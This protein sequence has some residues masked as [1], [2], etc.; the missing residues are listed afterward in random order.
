MSST[1][2]ANS[3]VTPPH[4]HR[5]PCRHNSSPRPHSGLASHKYL[6]LTKLFK[7]KNVPCW[8]KSWLHRTESCLHFLIK[9]LYLL[10]GHLCACWSKFQ[11][12]YLGQTWRSS[13]LDRIVT[14]P[15]RI[16]QK[17]CKLFKLTWVFLQDG[18]VKI[19]RRPGIMRLA[20]WYIHEPWAWLALDTEP[21]FVG[22]G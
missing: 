6:Y 3:E 1:H 13:L 20:T 8:E 14:N 21:D 7:K 19:P 4:Y 15:S 17:F 12:W 16:Y 5:R 22:I 11:V 9:S 2:L 10:Q 18:C